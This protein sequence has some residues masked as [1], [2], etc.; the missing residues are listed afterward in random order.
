M[1]GKGD[2]GCV[3]QNCSNFVEDLPSCTLM[4][5]RT[6][7]TEMHFSIQNVCFSFSVKREVRRPLHR[8]NKIVFLLM[9]VNELDHKM[10]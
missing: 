1:K 7:L 4:F 6:V 2:N 9:G 8:L 3:C 5:V 10:G